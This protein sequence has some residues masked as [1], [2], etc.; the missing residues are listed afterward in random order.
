MQLIE[1]L[2]WDIWH[3]HTDP[4]FYKTMAVGVLSL[5]SG[6]LRKALAAFDKIIAIDPNV[7]E[8]QDKRTTIYS[9]IGRCTASKN[10]IQHAL[11]LEP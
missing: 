1:R 9:M 2:T 10:H 4:Q 6:A 7:A 11:Y 8:G 5:R 3:T